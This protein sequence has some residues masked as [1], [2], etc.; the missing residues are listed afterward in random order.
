LKLIS[1]KTHLTFV[2]G[3]LV[4]NV[5][6]SFRYVIGLEDLKNGCS[7]GWLSALANTTGK[8]F[9]L[10][11]VEENVTTPGENIVMITGHRKLLYLKNYRC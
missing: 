11:P 1:F 7:F 6:L 8:Q 10:V 4:Y 5:C 2:F 3:G 9:Y